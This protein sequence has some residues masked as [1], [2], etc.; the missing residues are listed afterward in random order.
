[1]TLLIRRLVIACAL[2]GLGSSLAS[3]MVHYRLLREP[4]YTSFCDVNAT[5]S[6][7]E[8]Y[9]SRFGSVAGV[10]VALIGALWFGFVLLLSSAAGPRAARAFRESVPG[11]LFAL[12]TLALATILYLA[13]VSFFVLGAVCLLCVA[14]YVAVVGLFILSGTA[15]SLPMTSLPGRAMRDVRAL[16]GNP[17]ALAVSVA[18][19]LVAALAIG[20]FPR[21]AATSAAAAG[22]GA[23]PD[24]EVQSEF[25]RWYSTQ[26]RVQVPVPNE[27]AAVLIVKFNDYQCPPCRQTFMEYEGILA[28][29]GASHPGAVRFVT[30]DY[31]LDPECNVNAPN[32]AHIAACEAAVA[33][34]LARRHD[35]APALEKYFFSNQEALSPAVVRQAAQQV[36]GVTDFGAEYART[37]EQ[38]KADIALGNLLGVSATPT[39]FIN[40]VKVQGGLQPQFFDAAIAYELKKAGK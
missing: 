4:G 28:K 40:G 14:T 29:Y 38:V 18:Y 9:L 34:R 17:G 33:V 20:F 21:E 36:G 16:F 1:M 7:T 2:V 30:K 8:A 13:Y 10:P 6:C 15:A 19:L 32:G 39:F 12:T 3:T 37:V 31:P 22:S 24:Q 25:E 27:G 5:V 11:Y 26:P 23:R 35:K